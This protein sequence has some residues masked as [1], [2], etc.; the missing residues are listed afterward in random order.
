[1]EILLRE[2]TNPWMSNACQTQYQCLLLDKDRLTFNKSLAIN[3]ATLL[4]DD[5]TEDICNFCYQKNK[6]AKIRGRKDSLI[7]STEFGIPLV[8]LSITY[9]VWIHL[10]ITSQGKNSFCVKRDPSFPA[11]KKKFVWNKGFL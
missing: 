10:A 1:M 3:P 7:T 4:P 5:N 11:L 2:A 8:T 6:T 9:E